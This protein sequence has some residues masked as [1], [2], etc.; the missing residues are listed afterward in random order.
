MGESEH[1]CDC[2]AFNS[3]MWEM[4]AAHLAYVPVKK[5]ISH[6]YQRCLNYKQTDTTKYVLMCIKDACITYTTKQKHEKTT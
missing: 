4:I 6:V 2:I 5:T 1:M 3:G